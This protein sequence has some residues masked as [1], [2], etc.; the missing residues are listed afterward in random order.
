[1]RQQGERR[2]MHRAIT[3]YGFEFGPAKVNRLLCDEKKGWVVLSIETPKYPAGREIQIYVTK[4][5][6][7]R[8]FSDGEWTPPKD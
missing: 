7:V 2:G 1:M 8:I 3:E 5:G 6:K 4:T